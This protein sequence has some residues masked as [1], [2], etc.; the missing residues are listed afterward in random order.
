MSV[1]GF[2][3]GSFGDVLSILK[4]AY[5]V[6][7]LLS[8]SKGASDEYQQLLAELDTSLRTLHLVQ[9][10]F[11]AKDAA[12]LPSDVQTAIQQ[13]VS[14][15]R[16][17]ISELYAKIARFRDS[18][19]K[20][21]SG[22][23]MRDSWRK[24]GWGLFKHDELVETRRRLSEQTSI[25]RSLLGLSNSYVCRL[26]GLYRSHRLAYFS[27]TIT[28]VDHQVRASHAAILEIS[29]CVQ[30]IPQV[31][32][33]S[34]EGGLNPDSRPISLV[35]VLGQS[36]RLPLELCSTWEVSSVVFVPFVQRFV[37]PIVM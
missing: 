13:S 14:N 27:I 16:T 2:T 9:G 28:R 3:F 11:L 20:G 7:A 31:L 12:S 24:I 1:I 26:I 4:M 30:G 22:S 33:Y 29:R 21:G 23:M 10:V 25:I 37:E 19:Q 8:E 6:R 36:I 15:S 17:L 35:D 32:G 5:D 18:L 34:W